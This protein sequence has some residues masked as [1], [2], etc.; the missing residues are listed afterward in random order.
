[1]RGEVCFITKI[2]AQI[3]QNTG[4]TEGRDELHPLLRL[5]ILPYFKIQAYLESFRQP[6]LNGISQSVCKV[7]T[8]GILNWHKI[9]GS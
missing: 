3:I 8:Y 5:L 6:R 4:I 9:V 7:G 1:M 2:V